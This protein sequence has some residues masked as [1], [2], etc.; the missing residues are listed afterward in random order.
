MFSH[1]SIPHGISV[2]ILTTHRVSDHGLATYR[3]FD[4]GKGSLGSHVGGQVHVNLIDGL[5][6][7]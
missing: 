4:H 1:G 2:Y 5:R 6:L 3:I 7:S